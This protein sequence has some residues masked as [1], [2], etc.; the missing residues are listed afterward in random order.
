MSRKIVI[1]LSFVT[2]IA[3]SFFAGTYSTKIDATNEIT[4]EVFLEVMDDLMDNH[5]LQPTREMLLEGAVDGM[6]E[7]LN[8]PFTTYFDLE[9]REDYEASFG[10]SYVGIGV[11]VEFLEELIVVKTVVKDGPADTAGIRVNDIIAQVDG[12]SI[13]NLPFYES[14]GMILGDIDTEV[15]IG[16]VRNG[17]EGVINLTMT[18]EVIPNATVIVDSFIRDDER[19]E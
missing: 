8:D 7:S 15:S 13:V 16:V 5:Y 4:D 19:N 11:T 9:E 6:I 2:A 3:A 17:V 10:E 1:I 12:E 14:I 18:R